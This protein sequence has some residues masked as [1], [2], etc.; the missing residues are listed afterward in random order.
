MKPRR[1]N[2]GGGGKG[3]HSARRQAGG[4]R[5]G[6]HEN[7][8]EPR[9]YGNNREKIYIYGKHALA[10]ALANMPRVIRKVFLSTEAKMG[11]RE[12]PEGRELLK[13]AEKA[14]PFE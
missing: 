1:G 10:E 11:M 2:F 14:N 6:R 4:V 8:S 12:D 5:H 3:K 7:R 13:N 9:Q